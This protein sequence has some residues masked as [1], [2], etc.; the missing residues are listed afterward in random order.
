MA[1]DNEKN[2]EVKNELMETPGD[3]LSK[4]REEVGLSIDDVAEKLNL[5]PLQIRSLE[6]QKLYKN[7]FSFKISQIF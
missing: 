6:K 3:I 7:I 5:Q 1:T 2:D 4:K